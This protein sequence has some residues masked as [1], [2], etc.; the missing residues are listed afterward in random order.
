MMMMIIIVRNP[1]LPTVRFLVCLFV[2]LLIKVVKVVKVAK[3][4]KV[5]YFFALRQHEL[6]KELSN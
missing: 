4:A 2:T 5:V 3:Y 6:Y 1:T